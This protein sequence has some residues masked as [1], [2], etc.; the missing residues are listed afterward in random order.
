MRKAITW[1]VMAVLLA[2]R[3][4]LAQTGISSTSTNIAKPSG[5]GAGEYLGAFLKDPLIWALVI[6]LIVLIGLFFW[7]RNRNTEE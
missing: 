6:G 5:G 4:A 7:V 1:V 3:P 2:V